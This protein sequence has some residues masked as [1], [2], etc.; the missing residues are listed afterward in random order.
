MKNLKCPPT[1]T[2]FEELDDQNPNTAIKYEIQ[3]M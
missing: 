3:K 1:L 2:P